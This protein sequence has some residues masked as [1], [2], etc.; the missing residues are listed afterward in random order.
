[1]NNKVKY[2]YEFVIEEDALETYLSINL[3][4]EISVVKE[5]LEANTF[6]VTNIE[7]ILELLDGVLREKSEYEEYAGNTCTIEIRKKVLL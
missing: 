7:E 4:K 5:F 2:K 3:P 6:D 1:M